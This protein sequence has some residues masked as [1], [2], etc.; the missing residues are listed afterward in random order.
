MIK[1]T[2]L[3]NNDDYDEELQEK[4]ISN[5]S[6]RDLEIIYSDSILL[7]YAVFD[8]MM[9]G[10]FSQEKRNEIIYQ[11]NNL[12]F[13]IQP[14]NF[15]KSLEKATKTKHGAYLSKRNLSSLK[16]M[17]VFKVKDI[18]AGFALCSGKGIPSFSEIVAVHNISE[19]PNIGIYLIGAAVRLG[20]KYLNC[21]GEHLSKA[22]YAGAGF[23]VYK[24]M[25]DVKMRNGKNEVLYFMK[26]RNT[27]VPNS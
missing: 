4:K 23:K 26:Y 25:P 10:K 9:E 27:P 11:I 16:K 14:E 22:L 6:T 12:D 8:R 24:E 15:F 17:K 13:D 5:L 21:F 19:F 2:G 1:I 3:F 7:S 20:G 18:D